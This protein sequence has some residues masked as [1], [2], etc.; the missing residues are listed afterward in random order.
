MLFIHQSITTLSAH[1][2]TGIIPT[3]SIQHHT[4][5]WMVVI[6]NYSCTLCQFGQ[7]L[8]VSWCPCCAALADVAGLVTG[9]FTA[10]HASHAVPTTKREVVS[11][12]CI[13][14]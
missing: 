10:F 8:V 12:T 1:K 14:H 4:H 13:T 6:H 7:S 2:H 5:S 3:L 11:V 9:P